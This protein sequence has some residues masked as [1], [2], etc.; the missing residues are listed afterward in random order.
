[1]KHLMDKK[2]SNR[3]AG[4]IVAGIVIFS[5]LMGYIISTIIVTLIINQ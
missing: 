4:L 1:M 5:A 2:M 3:K